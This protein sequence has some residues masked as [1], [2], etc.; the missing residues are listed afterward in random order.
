VILFNII[1]L[2]LLL[3]L[4]VNFHLP[5]NTLFW[6]SLQNSGHTIAFLLATILTLKSI[7]LT[8]LASTT[9]YLLALTLLF[10]IGT[11]IELV[12]HLSGRG[13]SASDLLLNT[14]GIVIG[15]CFFIASDKRTN[16]KL[17][18]KVSMFILAIVLTGWVMYKPTH[19][20]ISNTFAPDIPKLMDFDFIGASAKIRGYGSDIEI[21]THTEQWPENQSKSAKVTFKPGKWS[22][23]RVLEAAENWNGYEWFTFKVLNK[24]TT[25]IKLMIRVDDQSINHVDHSHMS[26]RRQIPIGTSTVRISFKELAAEAQ[27]RGEAKFDQIKRFLVYIPRNKTTTTLYFDDFLIE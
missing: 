12:Q 27:E 3:L 8:K 9:A 14:I 18:L 25:E 20:L 5:G 19:Y 7:A 4:F 6:N 16:A 21:A 15:A 26:T 10:L 17:S 24:N 22:S 2:S 23:M 1:F 13:V 11:L